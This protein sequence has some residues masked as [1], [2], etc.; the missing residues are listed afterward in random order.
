MLIIPIWAK[1]R[2]LWM[3]S[4]ETKE[5]S[6]RIVTTGRIINLSLRIAG[7]GHI[8][9]ILEF[10]TMKTL[11]FKSEYKK[12]WRMNQNHYSLQLKACLSHLSLHWFWTTTKADS[13]S[14]FLI[15]L[16]EIILIKKTCSAKSKVS[17]SWPISSNLRS[18]E[19]SKQPSL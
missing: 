18:I 16:D 15:K 6:H 17:G 5:T 2:W 11:H 4:H 8:W 7:L 1:V 3:M 9:R 10:R 12:K 19:K 13:N 14:F